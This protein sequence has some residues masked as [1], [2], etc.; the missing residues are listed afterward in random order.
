MKKVQ[1]TAESGA[2]KHITTVI[3]VTSVKWIH[4]SRW[5]RHSSASVYSGAIN[6]RRKEINHA[7][8]SRSASPIRASPSVVPMSSIASGFTSDAICGTTA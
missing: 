7:L 2:A 4:P 6:I 8:P 3:S 1:S 5:H